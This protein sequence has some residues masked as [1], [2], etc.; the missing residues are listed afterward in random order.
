MD[1]ASEGN[2][3]QKGFNQLCM[4]IISRDQNMYSQGRKKSCAS[5]AQSAAGF[6][7]NPQKQGGDH[8]PD[9]GL[10]MSVLSCL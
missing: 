2:E 7:K 3:I 10:S 9:E 5:S 1:A 8:N 4:S 6:K